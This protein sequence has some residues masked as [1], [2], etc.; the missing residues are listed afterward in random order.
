MAKT[1]RAVAIFGKDER[2]INV[3]IEALGLSGIVVETVSIGG[4]DVDLLGDGER[5]AVGV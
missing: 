4:F 3:L 2:Y 5:E 1:E